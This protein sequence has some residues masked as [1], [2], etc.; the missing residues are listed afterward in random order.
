MNTFT[1]DQIAVVPMLFW[2]LTG[3]F[4]AKALAFSVNSCIIALFY[5][6]KD[7]QI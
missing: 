1:I 5:R 6:K 2:E 7:A 3:S 4:P